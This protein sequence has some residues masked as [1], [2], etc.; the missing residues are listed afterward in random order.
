MT[1]CAGWITGDHAF[2]AVDSAVTLQG[3]RVAKQY[4]VSRTTFGEREISE[5]GTVT[6]EAA[7]KL[8]RLSNRFVAAFAGLTEPA[9]PVL[10]LLR[11]DL[12]LG[13]GIL[14]R[15]GTSACRD[16]GRTPASLDHKL[17]F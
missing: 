12:E 3:A 5:S 1:L 10:N 16:F 14:A 7:A 11:A 13:T 15:P 2:L 17:G 8:F 9:F 4:A 6:M